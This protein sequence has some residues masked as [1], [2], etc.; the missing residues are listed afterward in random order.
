MYKMYES[1]IT[2]GVHLCRL[3]QTHTETE[4]ARLILQAP[5]CITSMAQRMLFQKRR[6]ENTAEGG[7]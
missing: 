7:R 5:V 2:Y 4:N 3:V 6:Y 1:R